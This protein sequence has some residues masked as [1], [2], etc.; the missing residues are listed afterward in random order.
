MR[1]D[2]GFINADV[3]EPLAALV[4]SLVRQRQQG[5]GNPNVPVGQRRTG[6]ELV[7]RSQHGVGGVEHRADSL[8]GCREAEAFGWLL[9]VRQQESVG[10][11]VDIRL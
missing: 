11:D 2:G 10:D 3:A 6:S 9:S 7:D 4:E 1:P 8:E 5:V